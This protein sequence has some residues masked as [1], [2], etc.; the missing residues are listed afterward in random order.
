MYCTVLSIILFSYGEWM[1]WCSLK[2]L[3]ACGY[4]VPPSVVHI[5]RRTYLDRDQFDPRIEWLACRNCLVN[6]KTLETKPH[7]SD[8]M[9]T[10]QI[11]WDYKS[12][13]NITSFFDL[14]E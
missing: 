13:S 10:I 1:W 11:P 7:S 5:R 8:F 6:L 3:Q 4:H 12:I 14:V 2:N 9:A